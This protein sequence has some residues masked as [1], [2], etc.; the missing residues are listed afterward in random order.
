MSH[1]RCFVEK[2]GVQF[3][4]RGES[5]SDPRPGDFILLH[6]SNW[7]S[8]LIHFGQKLRY[9]GKDSK[10]TLWN[11]AA[12]II[13]TDGDIIEALNSGVRKSNL[14]KYKEVAYH[15]VRIKANREDR[16]EAVHFAYYAL[17]EKYGKL[18][19][20]S[21]AIS[22]ITGLK[23]SFGFDGQQI[24]SGLVARALERTTAI[25]TSEPSHITPAD[26]AKYYQV[27]PTATH[28]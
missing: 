16:Q 10:Y 14:L 11:H 15:L 28:T 20:V 4:G 8:N 27:N 24:C 26:L 21:I 3:F 13:N 22:F 19:I 6:T 12:L 18:T 17:G 2:E 1:S 7:S 25:F 23:F 9:H 5:T